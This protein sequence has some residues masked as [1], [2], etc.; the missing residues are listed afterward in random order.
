MTPTLAT[1]LAITSLAPAP[2]ELRGGRMIM[3]PIVDIS[4]DGV[5]VGGDE[6][7]V[8][9]WDNVRSVDSE[10]SERAAVYKEISDDAWRARVRLA[11]GDAVLAAPL[12]ERLFP[13]YQ[14]RT[15][16]LALMIAEGV[17]QCRY[18]SGDIAGAFDAW[19]VAGDLRERG[20]EIAGDPQ[21][22]PLLDPAT[23][24]PPKVPPIFLDGL[25]AQRIADSATEWLESSSAPTSDRMKRIVTAY[26]T[27]APGPSQ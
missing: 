2:V 15:G 18:G 16:S 12:F 11:R 25:V 27:A 14:D 8:I 4:P 20:V 10:W 17:Y 9:A 19:L 1:L 24:L 22:S 21:M 23:H 3:A 5:R 26:Q 7:R 13:K 6:P